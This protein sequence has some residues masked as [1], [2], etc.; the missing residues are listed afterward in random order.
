MNL[1]K[2]WSILIDNKLTHPDGKQS[3][4]EAFNNAKGIFS[5]KLN[6][7]LGR[8][9]KI[10]YDNGRIVVTYYSEDFSYMKNPP[11]R[12]QILV[13]HVQAPQKPPRLS[14]D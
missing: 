3:F 2:I 14:N 7:P 12:E 5:F 11:F 13:C 9:G 6:G 1:E 8:G 4:I 10:W